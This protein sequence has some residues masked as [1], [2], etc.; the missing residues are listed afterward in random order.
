M[1]NLE[2]IFELK[3]VKYRDIL[4]ITHLEI[5][6]NVVTCIVGES[7]SGKTTLLRLLNHLI[8]CD[9]GEVLYKGQDLKTIDPIS[10][11]RRVM[12]LPQNPVVFSGNIQENM[13]IG[14]NF[15]EKPP[16]STTQLLHFLNL[17]ALKKEVQQNALSLSGGEKQ[18]LAVARLLLLDPEVML[19]DE[20]SA[21][22]DEGTEDLMMS[23]LKDYVIQNNKTLIMVTHS[24]AIWSAYGDFVVTIKEGRVASQKG[25]NQG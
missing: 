9:R 19:L 20:P 8:S 18:R 23:G 3:E 22:L 21:A 1:N 17:V 16:V 10:L 24:K 15:A 7:G 14:L 5:P 6:A 12:M 2:P 11:R 13:L 25:G 4:D